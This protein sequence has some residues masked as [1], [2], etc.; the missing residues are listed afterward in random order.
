M[1]TLP[2]L[3]RTAEDGLRWLRRQKDVQ[4]A[5]VFVA[6]NASLTARLNYTSHIPCNG[7]EEPKS[8]ESY[9]IGV[10]AVFG[11]GKS[12]CIGLGSE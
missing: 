6:S 4:E 11:N 7:V 12:P 10:R 9:G 8:S 1:I 2:I 3:K 5:E